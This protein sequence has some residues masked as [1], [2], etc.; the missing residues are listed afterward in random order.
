MKK[1]FTISVVTAYFFM[2]VTASCSHEN[3][4]LAHHHHEDEHEHGHE[5]EHE[6]HDENAG[7]EI[8]LEPEKAERMGVKTLVVEPGAFCDVINATGV[9]SAS[10]STSGT[11]SSPTSGILT[12]ADGVAI[13]T[14]VR[15]GQV[16]GRVDASGVVG[17]D[18]NAASLAALNAA[19]YEVERL[20]PLYEQQLVTA[21][22]Y[23]E[24]LAALKIAQ[25]SYSPAAAT[26][27]VTAPL[28]GIITELNVSQGQYVGPG[29]IVARISDGSQIVLTADVPDKYASQ[30]E[31]IANVNIRRTGDDAAVDLAQFGLKRI[32]GASMPSTK[33]GYVTAVFTF[34][35]NAGFIPGSIVEVYLLG[36]ECEDV[37]SVPLSAITEQ[38]GQHFVYVRLDEEGYMK[39][40]V[41]LGRRDGQR[42][43]IL[44][45]VHSG[46]E[47]VVE[48]VTALRLA[49]TSGNVPEGHTHSH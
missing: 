33:P 12:L 7:E 28:G 43:E 18:S 30:M 4:E 39:S 40:P 2:M 32:S 1:V 34:E 14:E 21:E 38:Q 19:K 11:A 9:L 46:D 36:N 16:I 35:N 31:N 10:T 44:S 47:I 24:A 20:K 26:G 6:G 45:G 5:H 3:N 22:K 42:V 49:E 37:V 27:T 29:D 15:K 41:S 8:I 25:A 48:G 17:G 23:N 13:G